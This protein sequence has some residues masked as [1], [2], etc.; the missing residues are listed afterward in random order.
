[1]VKIIKSF[2]IFRKTNKKK[3]V[4]KNKNNIDPE[5]VAAFEQLMK[6]RENKNP[7]TDGLNKLRDLF[8]IKPNG[9][10]PRN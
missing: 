6:D 10:K 5:Y 8:K 4:M 1:M 7:F 2:V 9:H 3:L